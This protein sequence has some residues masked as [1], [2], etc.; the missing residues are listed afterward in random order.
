MFQVLKFSCDVS[1]ATYPHVGQALT[2]RTK[3]EAK[4]YAAR[5]LLIKLQVAA[6]VDGLTESSGEPKKNKA[7]AKAYA[8]RDLLIKLQVAA[9]VDGLTESSGE[10][11]KIAHDPIPPPVI[12]KASPK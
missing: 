11:K 9:A 4:A 1:L 12:P 2:R 10:P 7:E 6:A 5:D 8:A 3:A